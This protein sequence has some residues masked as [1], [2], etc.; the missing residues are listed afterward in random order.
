MS[1]ASEEVEEAN[2][3]R[4]IRLRTELTFYPLVDDGDLA[5]FD[6]DD[7]LS[8]DDLG[9]ILA[10]TH[11]IE[12]NRDIEEIDSFNTMIRQI[13][14]QSNVQLD[15]IGGGNN[16]EGETVLV[17]EIVDYEVDDL[18]SANS[19]LDRVHSKISEWYSEIPNEKVDT[20]KVSQ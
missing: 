10:R 1:E 8:E 2:G 9:K 17:F 19:L 12:T 18:V 5:G 15:L 6:E 11:L 7:E 4:K 16:E 14:Q 20:R 3:V 13:E